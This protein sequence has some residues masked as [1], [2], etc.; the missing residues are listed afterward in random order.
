MIKCLICNVE[1]KSSIARHLRDIHQITPDEYRV[2]F[3]GA[4]VISQELSEKITHA[5]KKLWSNHDYHH[6]MCLSRQETHR[7]DEFRK[8]QSAIIKS[9]YNNGHKT[10]N[11]GL[12][13][14]DDTRLTSIGKKN[15]E[16]LTGRKAESYAYLKA[17][18]DF[19]K[20]HVSDE[21]KHRLSWSEERKRA[22]RQRISEAVSNAI[23]RNSRFETLSRYKK[24]WYHTKQGNDEYYDSGWELEFMHKLSE[25]TTLTWTKNH[26]YVIH[27]T[28]VNH[29]LRRYVPDFLIESEQKKC[30]L[31]LKGYVRDVD[32]LARKSHVAKQFFDELQIGYVV[33]YNVSDAIE[34]VRKFFEIGEF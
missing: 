21:F 12:T 19:M 13:K 6:S 22:W 29:D 18:S 31:E 3:D 15:R 27:Y 24:G 32:E 16:A 8:K 26:R 9:A 2:Q 33:C 5:Q 14:F 11:D 23:A 1:K 4:N 28:D 10:W 25:F 17:H 34:H 30:V 20:S 7:T